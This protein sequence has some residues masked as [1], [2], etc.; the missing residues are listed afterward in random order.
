MRGATRYPGLF[1]GSGG[2][3]CGACAKADW[4]APLPG[5]RS[6]APVAFTLVNAHRRFSRL[7]TA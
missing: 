2:C 1:D 3:R 7:N 4:A 6:H 5:W